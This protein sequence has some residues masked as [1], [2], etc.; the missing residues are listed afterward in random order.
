MLHSRFPVTAALVAILAGLLAASA[1]FA[2]VARNTIDPV[3]VVSQDGRHL[4]VTGPVECTPGE[5]SR[6]RVTV[7]QRSTGAVA[8]GR[9]FETCTG[10]AQQW[11]VEA[12]I[13]GKAKF[14]EGP[15][16]AVAIAVTSDRDSATDA[17]QW[18]VNVTLVA[19]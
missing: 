4:F 10:S 9:T 16:T 1:A 7:S 12:S 13:L 6:L 15:A 2:R 19:E 11:E 14:E 3:A 17:H 8:E 18:L 5:R